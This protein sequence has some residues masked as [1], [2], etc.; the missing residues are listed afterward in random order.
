MNL[1]VIGILT[2][3][4]KIRENT[5]EV[6]QNLNSQGIQTIMLT[7][8]NEIAAQKVANE[9]GIKDFYSNLLPEDKLNILDNIRK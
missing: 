3:V 1:G 4:D 9:I 5:S 7:G 2:V 6:I 8:D